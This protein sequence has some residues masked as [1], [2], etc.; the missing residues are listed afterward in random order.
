VS[1]TEDFEGFLSD[2]KDRIEEAKD[3][4]AEAVDAHNQG[5]DNALG[6]AWSDVS[7]KLDDAIGA[8]MDAQDAW[9]KV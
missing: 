4:A 3:A 9:S 5:V 2:A 8:L 7:E 1:M 6:D